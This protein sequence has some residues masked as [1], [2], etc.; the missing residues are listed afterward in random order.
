MR[1]LRLNRKQRILRNLAVCLVLWL[2]TYAALDFPPYTVRGMLDRLERECFLSDL[3]LLVTE[4]ISRSST[5][6][7]DIHDIY[8]LARTGDTYVF[9]KYR[10]ICCGCG[11]M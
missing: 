5:D 7:H 10:G 9:G 11:S 6:W 2:T 4:D 1:K 3:E 8:L